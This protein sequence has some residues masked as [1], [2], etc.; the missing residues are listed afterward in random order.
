MSKGYLVIEK[1]ERRDTKSNEFV[2]KQREP[3]R[4]KLPVLLLIPLLT[5]SSCGQSPAEELQA[6][7]QIV[8]SWVATAR[9]VGEAW[10]KGSVPD[11]YARRTLETAQ[12]SL[13][14]AT[15]TLAEAEEIPAE[16]LTRA[17]E[18]IRNL[19]QTMSQMQAATERDDKPALQQS[20]NELT[21]QQSAFGVFAESVGEE[22]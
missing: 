22:R 10:T 20:L 16:Q 21:M 4:R 5:L 18:Q 8:A 1:S 13:K 15:E 2:S 6:E 3:M 9:M 12:E 7:T 19:Q 14:E 17:Q 11:A